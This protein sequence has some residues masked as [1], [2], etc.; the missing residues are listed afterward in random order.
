NGRLTIQGH[1]V[2][3][4]FSAQYVAN[5]AA[6]TG[7][8]SVLTQPT[9][10]TQDDWEN[11]TFSFGSLVLKDTDFG[12]GR[13]A[14][15]NTDIIA[16]NSSI[17]LGDSRVFIDKNDGQGMTVSLEEG[18][19][20]PVNDA[21]KS[22]FNGTITLNNNSSLNI[23][24]AIFNGE[25]IGGAGSNLKLSSGSTWKINT[26]TILSKLQ[27]NNGQISFISSD[28]SL[29][30]LTVNTMDANNMHIVMGVSTSNNMSD[31]LDIINNAAGGHN[32]L[33]L[34]YL[35]ARALTLKEDIT[36]ASAPAGTAHDYFSFSGIN[37]GFSIYTPDT[38]VMEKDGKVFWQLKHN[39]NS[40]P[41]NPSPVEPPQLPPNSNQGD[42]TPDTPSNIVPPAEAEQ[43]S[44]IS[45]DQRPNVEEPGSDN[46][47]SSIDD[48]THSNV[49][50]HG[51]DDKKLLSK[52]KRFFATRE[53]ILSDN[54]GHWMQI[55]DNNNHDGMWMSAIYSR[56]GY[57]SFDIRYNGFDTGVTKKINNN[58]LWGIDIQHYNGYNNS[59]DYRNNFYVLGA[60]VFVRDDI[61][62]GFFIDGSVGYKKISEK[63]SIRGELNDLS[64]KTNSHVISAGIRSGWKTHLKNTGI[65]LTPSVS[66]NTLK[67]DSSTLKGAERKVKLD[68]GSALWSSAGFITEKKIGA[69]TLDAGIW[70]SFSLKDIPG[71]TL[72]DARMSH[73]YGVNGNNRYRIKMGMDG[74][75]TDNMHIQL[76]F[77]SNIGRYFKNYNNGTLSVRYDF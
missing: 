63:I 44:D 70:R 5:A 67:T 32:T 19:S 33:D 57:D 73:H 47:S 2:T 9:S 58:I 75:V 74:K 53:F 6:S 77:N 65:S 41:D 51:R 64:G 3:H 16:D 61:S 38:Q 28:W 46:I 17:T 49:I 37:R 7:D 27:G 40:E 66:L 25:I 21:D 31:R 39:V 10:F 52:T 15:L 24:N 45:S 43:G 8:H 35:F 59:H 55:I 4:A 34:S 11:R 76:N 22:V 50:F 13:N 14:T 12:L 68:A 54:A 48:S 56:G 29:K 20:V 18:E 30:L 36:L 72:S 1:P 42:D 60:D 71:I 26:N 62:S 23:A 69:F